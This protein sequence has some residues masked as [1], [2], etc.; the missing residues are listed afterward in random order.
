MGKQ[1]PEN[2]NDAIIEKA[3]C[4]A[5]EPRKLHP[6][7]WFWSLIWEGCTSTLIVKVLQVHCS[8]GFAHF[9]QAEALN[10]Y[11]L[12]IFLLHSQLINVPIEHGTESLFHCGAYVL[13]IFLVSRASL[14]VWFTYL[15]ILW[16][17]LSGFIS[18]CIHLLGSKQMKMNHGR[19]IAHINVALH[20]KGFAKITQD[21]WLRIC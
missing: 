4:L 9:K 20:V 8:L 10:H 21:K 15:F 5:V 14:G 7:Q 1:Q 3:I 11:C 16:S 6:A 12:G 17:I 18:I 19:N 2:Q 13:Q